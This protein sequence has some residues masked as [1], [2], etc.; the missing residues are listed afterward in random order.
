[1]DDYPST[2]DA[3]CGVFMRKYAGFDADGNWR[4]FGPMISLHEPESRLALAKGA[5]LGSREE[6][7]VNGRH[8]LAE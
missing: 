8:G 2:F 6:L 5:V 3:P 1:M 7:G 4:R